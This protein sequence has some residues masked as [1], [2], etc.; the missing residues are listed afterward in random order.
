MKQIK[1]VCQLSG[2]SKR[3]LQFYDEKGL[4]NVQRSD[5]N[6]RIYGEEDIQRIWKILVYKEMGFSLSEIGELLDAGEESDRAFLVSKTLEIEAE[7]AE[8]ERMQVFIDKVLRYGLPD[9]DVSVVQDGSM[10]FA[11]YAK[12][13]SER[14]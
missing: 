1:E 12:V 3:T 8:L 7:I 4:L 10:T 9:Y 11:E 2:L 14:I 13:L 6:Y 5:S